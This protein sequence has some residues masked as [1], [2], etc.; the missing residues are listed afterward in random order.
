MSEES[1]TRKVKVTIVRQSDTPLSDRLKMWAFA[2][3]KVGEWF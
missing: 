2:L 3:S 1:S